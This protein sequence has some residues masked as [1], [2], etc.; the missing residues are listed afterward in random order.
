MSVWFTSDHHFNHVSMTEKGWRTGFR[1]VAEMNDLMVS[2]WNEVV[3]TKDQVWHLGDWALGDFREGLDMRKKLK[4][5]IHLIPGNHDRCH[6]A[7]RDSYKWQKVYFE[8]GFVS[9]QPFARR[10]VSGQNVLLSHF[11]YAGDRH[12]EDRFEQFRLQDKGLWLIHG[13]VHELWKR[14]GKQINVGVDQWDY[15]PVHLDTIA[16]LVEVAT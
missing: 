1:S 14:R 6:P 12:E 9:V 16:D 8:A 13:H 2:R 10:R 3:S 15:Y 4:G 7:H 5:E 11:P